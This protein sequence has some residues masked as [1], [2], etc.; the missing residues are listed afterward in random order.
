MKL[1]SLVLA[2]GC[3]LVASGLELTFEME[4]SATQCFKEHAK[5][6]TSVTLEYQVVLGGKLDIDVTV[7][8]PT[9]SVLL[10]DQRKNYD[11]YTWK[12]ETTGDFEFCFSNEFS[13][14][15]HKTVY[16][17]LQVGEHEPLSPQMEEQ[18]TALTLIE[19]STVTIHER[20][21]KIIDFQTHHRM[22]EAVGRERAEDL[23]ERVQFWS[24]GQT[25]IIVGVSFGQV[26]MVRQLFAN[27]GGRQ[28]V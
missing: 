16:F 11:S 19:T 27:A 23:N 12:A 25:I 14:F 17:D 7:T 10:K 9:G 2:F 6:G 4:P 15:T 13:T 26:Y 3:L 20:L 8:S 22:R 5:E 18:D 28:R 1:L 24:L 21:E